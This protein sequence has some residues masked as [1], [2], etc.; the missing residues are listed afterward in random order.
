MANAQFD[1]SA[2]TPEVCRENAIMAWSDRGNGG[3]A[4]VVCRRRSCRPGQHPGDPHLSWPPPVSRR[5]A[6]ARQP[7]AM[8]LGS[9][10]QFLGRPIAPARALKPRLPSQAKE[11]AKEAGSPYLLLTT[12]KH[13]QK[14]SGG[15]CWA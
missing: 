9:V 6:A 12:I 10:R 15:G 8:P 14:H 1:G 3:D 5:A 7:P 2:P 4:D 13:E 11:E